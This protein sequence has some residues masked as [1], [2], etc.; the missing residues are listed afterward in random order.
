MKHLIIKALEKA[1]IILDKQTPQTKKE[2]Q[3][4]SIIDV[5]P[6]ELLKFMKEN[7]IPDDAYFSGADN[8]YDAWDDIVLEWEVNVPTTEKDKLSFKRKR[9]TSLAW[10]CIYDM[11]IGRYERVGFNSKLLKQFDDTTIYDMYINKEFDRLVKYYS[12]YFNKR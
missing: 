3:S 10:K 1:F 2:T 11:L 12:L 6:K 4:I 8:G 7:N 9:F 5:N